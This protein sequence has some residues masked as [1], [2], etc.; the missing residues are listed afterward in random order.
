MGRVVFGS[1]E[2]AAAGYGYGKRCSAA[3]GAAVG[4]WGGW[5]GQELRIAVGAGGLQRLRWSHIHS[6]FAWRTQMQ[7]TTAGYILVAVG[8]G[9]ERVFWKPEQ[10]CCYAAVVAMRTRVV[11]Y[12]G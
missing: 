8:G 2:R 1:E 5:R 3:V 10:R 4:A 9:E 11:M 12:A 6:A 7:S